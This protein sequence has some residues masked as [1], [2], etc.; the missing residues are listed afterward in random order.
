M[1]EFKAALR[2]KLSQEGEALPDGSFPI[3]NEKDLKNAI[4]S[5]GR[6][7]DPEKAKAWIKQR[8]KALGLEK[9]IPEAWVSNIPAAKAVR[10]KPSNNQFVAKAVRKKVMN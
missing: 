3:R 8:A 7:K 5:Y 1:A 2:K 9:L 10:K 6:S 4:S